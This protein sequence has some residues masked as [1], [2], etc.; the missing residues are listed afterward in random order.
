[1]QINLQV[2]YIIEADYSNDLLA[3]PLVYMS[4]LIATAPSQAESPMHGLPKRS[5]YIPR[6]LNPDASSSIVIVD[7]VKSWNQ[8]LKTRTSWVSSTT[9]Y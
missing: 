7:S 2:Q 3:T 1:M 4:G 9:M 8:V 5:A 6:T